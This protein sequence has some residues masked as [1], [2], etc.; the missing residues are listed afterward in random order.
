MTQF[1]CPLCGKFNVKDGFETNPSDE[2]AA[3]NMVGKGRGKGFRKVNEHF[4]DDDD[5]VVETLN[6]RIQV[7]YDWA[8]GESGDNEFCAG[9]CE[10]IEEALEDEYDWDYI[11]GDDPWPSLRERIS[12]LIGELESAEALA[13]ENED[14]D[15]SSWIN[16]IENALESNYSWD[17]NDDDWDALTERI[18]EII[19]EYE[20]AISESEDDD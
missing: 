3:F 20:A 14:Y 17:Y 9:L 4:L 12:T 13:E 10:T 18:S 5:P 7:L 16:A 2:I 1:A 19:N 15:F 11:P 8:F 6:D